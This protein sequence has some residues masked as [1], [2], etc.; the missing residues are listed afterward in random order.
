MSYYISGDTITNDIST[1]QFFHTKYFN[2]Y[3]KKFVTNKN[4]IHNMKD[5][6]VTPL[7]FITKIECLDKFYNEIV[8]SLNTKFVLITHYGSGEAGLH[9]KILNHPLLIKW[10]GQNMRII[11]DKTSGF[12]LGLENRY[13]KRTNIPKIKE[14][15]SNPKEK[16]LYL[17]FSLHTNRNRSKIM[18]SLLEKGFTKNQKLDWDQY[19][20]D[21]SKH[22][23]CI[24]PKG[25]GFDCH[26]NWECLYLGVIPIVEKSQHMSYFDDLPIL[27]VNTYDNISV[28]YL[29]QI[30]NDFQQKSFNM[31]K[32]SISYWNKKIRGHFKSS[33]M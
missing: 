23:F 30:Y 3:I 13:W 6:K 10:Y 11:S 25:S 4:L 33:D 5:N 29:N 26:R 16:L 31:D 15:C 32:L 17:N 1:I 8:T 21:L 12:P 22:K 9:D 19:M 14:Y 24:S 2:K 28:E 7:I 27:F 20:E 18:N